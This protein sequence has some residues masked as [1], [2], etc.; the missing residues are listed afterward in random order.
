LKTKRSGAG[1]IVGVVV[2]ERDGAV[3]GELDGLAEGIVVG[4]LEGAFVGIDVVGEAV[5]RFVVGRPVGL[6]D[7]C[8]VFPAASVGMSVGE[9]VGGV[10]TPL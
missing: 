4:A 9:L 3:V 10:K 8:R 7:G 6:G 2:G 5:G 1:A